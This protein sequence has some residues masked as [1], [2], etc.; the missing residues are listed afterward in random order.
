L[1]EE[2]MGVIF[3]SEPCDICG[4]QAPRELYYYGGK[5]GFFNSIVTC[6]TCHSLAS[7][8]PHLDHIPPQFMET[9]GGRDAYIAHMAEV[10][11]QRYLTPPP[12]HFCS[13]C[14]SHDLVYHDLWDAFQSN[15]KLLI[16]T[17]PRCATGHIEL[18]KIGYWD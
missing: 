11:F 9:F 15:N 18:R 6:Q 1:K 16:V 14:Q 10:I 12:M 5:L 8:I 4:Y 3:A 7:T 17:C 13:V 2:S